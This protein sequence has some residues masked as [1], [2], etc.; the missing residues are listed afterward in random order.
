MLVS[1]NLIA[2]SH[3]NKSPISTLISIELASVDKT[4][5][6][7]IRLH[8]DHD[9]AVAVDADDAVVVVPGGDNDQLGSSGHSGNHHRA[10]DDGH[11]LRPIAN[12]CRQLA[13]L[14]WNEGHFA[15]ADICYLGAALETSYGSIDNVSCR[16][17]V[18]QPS[19]DPLP[20]L[21]L[22]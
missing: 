14:N 8:N 19:F 10:C 13:L 7:S 2:S 1:Y 17:E 12:C 11:H 3:L 21:R 15:A 4:D 16:P 18:S 9:D 22:A 6:A 20:I 5:G